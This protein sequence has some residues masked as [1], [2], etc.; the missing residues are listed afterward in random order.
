MR[1]ARLGKQGKRTSKTFPQ[2]AEHLSAAPGIHSVGHLAPAQPARHTGAV[3]IL[4]SLPNTCAAMSM[5]WLWYS[6][7]VA[8]EQLH[9]E[10]SRAASHRADAAE[11]RVDLLWGDATAGLGVARRRLLGE[12]EDEGGEGTEDAGEQ[13]GGGRNKEVALGR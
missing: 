4:R 8:G 13:H 6:G 9:V 10:G 7:G 11:L 3:L 2:G 1:Y 12:E 5:Q